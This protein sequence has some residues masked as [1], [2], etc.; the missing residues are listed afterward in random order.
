[1]MKEKKKNTD[2]IKSE[3][4]MPHC[5]QDYGSPN[6]FFFNFDLFGVLSSVVSY[7][8]AGITTRSMLTLRRATMR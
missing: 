3:K 5:E 4:Y 1:M 8:T 2:Q 6:D 7:I